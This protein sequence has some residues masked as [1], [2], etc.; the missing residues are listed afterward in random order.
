MI[1]IRLKV[2]N[3]LV[4]K[5]VEPR[6]LLVDFLREGLNLTGTHTGCDTSLCGAC[7]VHV[8]DLA[9]KACT[10]LAVECDGTSVRTI[11]GVSADGSHPMQL[12]F[13]EKHGLQ[14]GFCTSGMIMT[15]IDIGRRLGA[16]S[17]A[18]IRSE[19]KGNICRCTGYQNIVSA[20]E[21][22]TQVMS[23]AEDVSSASEQQ[24]VKH[25]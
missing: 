1:E 8:D 17:R 10:M 4:V 18:D 19:L 6:T 24:E 13:R 5:E 11:E 23:L 12:S 2:N 16:P 9:I 14:C 25:A 20:I 3:K 15:G 22:G 7:V 21:A